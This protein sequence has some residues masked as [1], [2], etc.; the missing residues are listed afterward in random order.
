VLLTGARGLLGAAIV[1][2][3]SGAYEIVTPPRETLDLTSESSVARACAD[4]SPEIIIN[5]AAF[6]D[7]D[8]AEDDAPSA[9]AVNAFGVLSLA[10][11][12]RRAGATLVH[13]SSDFVFDGRAS[14]PYTEADPPNPRGT[15][16][17]SKLLGEWFALECPRAYVLRVESLFGRPGPAG[18]RRGS[19]GTIVERIAAGE[20]VPIFVDR[21]ASP[22]YTTDIARATRLMLQKHI[23]PG[24]YHCVNDGAATWA[25]IARAVARHLGRDAAFR[26]MTL[27]SAAMKASRPRYCALSNGK[28]REAGVPMPHWEDALRRFLAER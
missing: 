4:A 19:L 6:N 5:C 3:F 1:R 21:T 13:Y 14:A 26:P 15:Y 8:G 22:T 23:A 7:V 27:E 12:V 17:A 18:A 24:L 10:Q 11:Y 28:L 25:D 16:A 9:L 2:E 20:E